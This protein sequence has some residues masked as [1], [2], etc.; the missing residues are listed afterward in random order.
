MNKYGEVPAVT[1]KCRQGLKKVKGR[2]K[3]AS[4][5]HVRTLLKIVK[6]QPQWYLDEIADEF[7]RRHSTSLSDTTIWRTLRGHGYRLKVYNEVAQQQ[8]AAER[9]EYRE[10]MAQ[11]SDPRMFIFID[12]THKDR[13]AARR[14]RAWGKRGKKNNISKLFS[15]DGEVLY[16]LLAAADIDGFVAPAC[17]LVHRKGSRYGHGAY[18]RNSLVG[19]V[20]AGEA[21]GTVDAELFLWWVDHCLVPTL[22]N[23]ERG[24]PRSVVVVDNASIHKDPRFTEKIEKAGAKIIWTAPYRYTR[25]RIGILF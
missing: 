7:R 23:F 1:R 21:A 10:A 6:A 11:I 18:S 25:P 2:K 24:E 16:T 20:G 12:E 8:D 5:R 22:G 17:H 15:P 4:A 3:K 14:R 19:Q 9:C 13:N